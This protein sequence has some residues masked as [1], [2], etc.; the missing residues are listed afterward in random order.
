MRVL[1]LSLTVSMSILAGCA[2][3][4]DSTRPAIELPAQWNEAASGSSAL[5][6]DWWRGF[7]SAELAQLIDAAGCSLML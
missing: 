2:T 1:A 6:R 5:Q 7:Q 3:P 4:I